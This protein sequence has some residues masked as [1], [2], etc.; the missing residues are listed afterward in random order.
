MGIAALKKLVL[1]RVKCNASK[2]V[3]G[4]DNLKLSSVGPYKTAHV[5]LNGYYLLLLFIIFM[6][7]TQAIQR[8]YSSFH[9]RL[10]VP[11]QTEGARWMFER[12]FSNGVKGGILADEMGL[13]K[14]ILALA[15]YVGN[16]TAAPTLIVAPKSLV[17]QWVSECMR[18][19][20]VCPTVIRHRDLDA[21][22]R[23]D[24]EQCR[25]AITTYDALRHRNPGNA[26]KTTH[27]G[28]I[29]LDEAHAIKN[30]RSQRSVAARLLRADIKWCLTGTPV[31]RRKMDFLA[32]M[33]WIGV[34][35]TD[36][37]MMRKTYTLRR[38]F[39]DASK[40]CERLRLPPLHL[41]VHA[42]PFGS[43]EE[44]DMYR[45]L[46]EEARLR[47]AV[48]E[49]GVRSADNTTQHIME[50]IMRLRQAIVNPQLVREGR[51]EDRWMGHKTRVEELVRLVSE[52]PANSKTLI[53]THWNVEADDIVEG[54]HEKLGLRV[55]RIYGGVSDDMRAQ[56]VHEFNNGTSIDVLVLHIDV[57]GVG[58][59]LQRATH[60]YINSLDW[61][62]LNEMQAI[63]R[64]HR[65][66][67][68]HVVTATRFVTK[69]TIDEYMLNLH[70]RKLAYAADVLADPRIT[71]TLDAPGLSQLKEI[72]QYLE[73]NLS[74]I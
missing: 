34:E 68:D 14:S 8:V 3:V 61:S 30:V 66:G 54:L 52:Q 63:A 74:L 70:D 57:G 42:I 47:I 69:G 15:M 35:S 11:H 67:V 43:T 25:V 55:K 17:K 45:D 32:L 58:L 2:I 48:F 38:T 19:V 46:A 26:L 53:F 62:P 5:A 20:G 13:G 40:Q 31:T 36:Y 49:S 44:I 28:R 24:I 64:A 37:D 9:G 29:I 27:F 56:L 41:R 23:R 72:K 12:E 65:L 16:P 59:N 21:L 22:T 39:E 7:V 6:E 1:S 50:V 33:T 10:I 60:V 51:N 73:H 71:K 18:F 4:C